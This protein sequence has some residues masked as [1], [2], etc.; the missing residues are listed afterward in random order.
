MH[1]TVHHTVQYTVQYTVRYTVP[2]TVQYTLQC[3]VHYTVHYMVHCMA[4]L[5]RLP[6]LL[7][8]DGAGALGGEAGH[9]VLQPR[10]LLHDLGGQHV[11]P[12]REQLAHLHSALHYIVHCVVHCTVHDTVH[13]RSTRVERR[14]PT[15]MKVGPSRIRVSRNSPASFRRA[16][17]SSGSV[18]ALRLYL[19][20]G[21]RRA[22]GSGSG[23]GSRARLGLGRRRGLR[24][25]LGLGLGRDRSSRTVASRWRP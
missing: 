19:P 6:Q 21:G 22:P 14:R 25:R 24:L 23:S 3:T 17:M 15:L 1:H 9:V 20:G 5:H 11:H 13:D 12:G 4:H 8:D 10:E 18:T 2:Y 16:V 7:G